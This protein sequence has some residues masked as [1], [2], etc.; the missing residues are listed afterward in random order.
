MKELNARLAI[1]KLMRRLGNAE[2]NSTTGKLTI[3][4]YIKFNLTNFELI[5]PC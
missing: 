4:K 1:P 3:G 5:F 2:I